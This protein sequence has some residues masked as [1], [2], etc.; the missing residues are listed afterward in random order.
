MYFN[1]GTRYSSLFLQDLL[2]G[3]LEKTI[4]QGPF[5]EFQPVRVAAKKGVKGQLLGS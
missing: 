5:N 4:F 2:L 3:L 1:L